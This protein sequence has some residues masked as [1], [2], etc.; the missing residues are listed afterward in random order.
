MFSDIKDPILHGVKGDTYV[1]TSYGIY[2]NF[3]YLFGQ[4]GISVADDE[5]LAISLN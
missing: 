3:S 1:R 2:S 4:Y 5:R